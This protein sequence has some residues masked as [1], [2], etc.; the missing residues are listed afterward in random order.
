[1][2]S[3]QKNLSTYSGK[4]IIDISQK[5]FAILVSEWNSDVTEAFML[6]QSAPCL[7]RVQSE[8]I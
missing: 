1:M 5:K 7:N 4:N 8:K 6:V 2:A 3:S